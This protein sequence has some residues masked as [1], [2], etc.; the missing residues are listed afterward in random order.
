MIDGPQV[1][2]RI[3]QVGNSGVRGTIATHDLALGGNAAATPH[4]LLM[5]LGSMQ[6]SIPVRLAPELSLPDAKMPAFEVLYRTGNLVS[7]RSWVQESAVKWLKAIH[8]GVTFNATFGPYTAS[9]PRRGELLTTELFTDQLIRL[10]QCPKLVR[11]LNLRTK[12]AIARVL[13]CSKLVRPLNS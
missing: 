5:E 1:E 10:L 4:K 7:R 9:L 2:V 11:P 6:Q 12:Y 3:G 8:R 13:Q